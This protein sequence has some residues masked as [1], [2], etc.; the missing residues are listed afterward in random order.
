[1]LP[2]RGSQ[3]TNYFYSESA[4]RRGEQKVLCSVFSFT[5]HRLLGYCNFQSLAE[6]N[7]Q[8]DEDDE[9]LL[10]LII[11]ILL[12]FPLLQLFSLHEASYLCYLSANI[13]LAAIARGRV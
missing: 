13:S 5:C 10:P 3:T 7:H 12:P 4:S 11:I 8:A 6:R 1:M 2:K 9:T